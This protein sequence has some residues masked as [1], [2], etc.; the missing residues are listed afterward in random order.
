MK[1]GEIAQAPRTDKGK[2]PLLDAVEGEIHEHGFE[3]EPSGGA[4]VQLEPIPADQELVEEQVHSGMPLNTAP[5]DAD[6]PEPSTRRSS[7]R[8]SRA[9]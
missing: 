3:I 5:D 2:S 9:H 6:R 1:E 4:P 7:N 8:T